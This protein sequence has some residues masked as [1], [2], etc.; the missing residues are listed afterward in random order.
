[1]NCRDSIEFFPVSVEI[2]NLPLTLLT[3][4]ATEK[5]EWTLGHVEQ[6]DKLNIKKGTKAMVR[7]LHKLC[8][9]VMEAF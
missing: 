1:M 7:I 9:P 8:V 3:D 6:V 5:V 4:E 2:L